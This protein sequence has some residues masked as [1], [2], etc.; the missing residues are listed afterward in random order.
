ML[1]LPEVENIFGNERNGGRSDS[2][3][4]VVVI[5]LVPLL[6]A[7]LLLL[8]IVAF[9]ISNGTITFPVPPRSTTDMQAADRQHDCCAVPPAT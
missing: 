6:L 9:I 5:V 4:C 1:Q 7:S 8:I 2:T 3:M